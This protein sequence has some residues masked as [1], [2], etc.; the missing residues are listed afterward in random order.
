MVTVDFVLFRVTDGVE[1]SVKLT[2]AQ[3]QHWKT[4]GSENFVVIIVVVDCNAFS[5]PCCADAFVS[6]I[7]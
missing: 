5:S 1:C 4:T 7:F 2:A 3:V 6:S